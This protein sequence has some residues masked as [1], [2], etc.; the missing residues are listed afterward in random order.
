[1]ESLR[2]LA[3]RVPGGMAG[4]VILAAV[5]CGGTS[6]PLVNQVL[7]YQLQQA[8][9]NTSANTTRLDLVNQSQSTIQLDLLIDGTIVTISC[10][11]SDGRC[12]YTPTTCPTTIEVV[13]ELR[14]ND[15][16]ILI[17]GRNYNGNAAFTFTEGEFNCQSVFMFT[18]TEDNTT[19]Q[20]L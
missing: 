15:V 12:S 11:P 4:F 3:R 9:I 18:F 5:G 14:T 6:V 20:V 17:S 13:Q 8:G 19:A 1:M 16:G 10:A 7:D 2:K